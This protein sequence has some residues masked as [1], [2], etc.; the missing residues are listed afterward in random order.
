MPLE[1]FLLTIALIYLIAATLTDIK[2]REVP[3]WLNFSLII[4]ALS[5]RLLYSITQWNPSYILSGITYFII[6]LAIANILYYTKVFAGGDAKLLM[7]LGAV[8]APPPNFILPTIQLAN[9]QLTTLTFLN[10]FPATLIINLLIIGSIYS[11]IFTIALA[12]QKHKQFTKE[13]RKKA[14]Q[15]NLYP[16]IITTAI[17]ILASIL[18]KTN[19][20]PLALIVI[21]F[22]FLYIFAKTVEEV[23]MTY[24]INTKNITEGEWLSKPITIKNKTAA[25]AEIIIS[26]IF[27]CFMLEKNRHTIFELNGS[28]G[29]VC[30]V[31]KSTSQCIGKE[32]AA[33]KSKGLFTPYK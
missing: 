30:T 23:C 5:A 20:I 29:F 31:R 13:F 21:I 26:E 18:T 3:N 25:I 11:L 27:L 32:A 33:M 8:F 15:T 7:A 28:K 12:I 2:K 17:I 10:N 24:K 4:F 9:P 19:L 14:K 1:Y 16:Y 6:F 22:P